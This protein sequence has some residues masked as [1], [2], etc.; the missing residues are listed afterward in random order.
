MHHLDWYVWYVRR[1]HSCIGI[2]LTYI[3]HTSDIHLAYIDMCLIL[4]VCYSRTTFDIFL[5]Y[6]WANTGVYMLLSF[7]HNNCISIS[8]SAGY[9]TTANETLTLVVL[10]Q[11][12]IF[13]FICMFFERR[14]VL[15][16]AF[17]FKQQRT[18]RMLAWMQAY[19]FVPT[20]MD[21]KKRFLIEIQ[22]Y[23]ERIVV[24]DTH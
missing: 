13:V 15:L 1:L 8:K 6:C 24:L 16:R 18:F 19:H 2:H 14:G 10:T 9:I 4:Q 20:Q 11:F 3:W 17:D 22:L 7:T 21:T 12:F 5:P 23:S